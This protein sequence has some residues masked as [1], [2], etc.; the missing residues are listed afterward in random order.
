MATE[1]PSAVPTAVPTAVTTAPAADLEPL[2]AE[3]ALQLWEQAFGQAPWVRDDL[4][5]SAAGA[6]PLPRTLG[7]RNA[8]LMRLHAGWFGARLELLS[9]CPECAT[10]IE[11]T[12][13]CEALAPQLDGVPPDAAQR[14]ELDGHRV[15][16]RVPD[17]DAV[18]FASTALPQDATEPHAGLDLDPD[19]DFA[20]RLWSVCVLS[21]AREG[22][23]CRAADLPEPVRQAVAERMEALDPGASVSFTLECPGCAARWQAPLDI[24]LALWRKLQERAERLLID[25]DTLARA[26]GWA[27]HEVLALSALRRAAY[28]QLVRA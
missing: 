23:P 18:V 16:F 21:A 12:A 14:L 24:G 17:I 6:Q 1:M 4:L 11:F 22:R 8:A 15:E 26:Y 25:V 28:L 3:A 5:L 9:T 13:D 20:D 19:A 27:Q 10:M 2:P 7:A